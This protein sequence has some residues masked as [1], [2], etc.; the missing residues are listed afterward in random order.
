MKKLAF[1]LIVLLTT[2]VLGQEKILN[3][4]GVLLDSEGQPVAD[5]SYTAVFAIY[6]VETQ[7]NPLWTDTNVPLTT[8]NGA[9]N[10]S[11]GTGLVP[12]PSDVDFTQTIWIGIQISGS[13]F[14]SRI[15]VDPEPTALSVQDSLISELS[16]LK[17]E[18]ESLI[19]SRGSSVP[20]GTIMAYA[21]NDTTKIPEGWLLCNGRIYDEADYPDLRLLIGTTWGTA[22]AG[23]F[24]VPD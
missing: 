11:L 3:Y 22:P 5:D 2:N 9:F 4:Q 19:A 15:R 1:L 6:D 8:V 24:R 10:V 12:I 23:Q 21:V 17:N 13:T 14:T 16:D 18:L 20:V 7:G